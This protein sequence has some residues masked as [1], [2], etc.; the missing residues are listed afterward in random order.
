[1]SL[2]G[3]TFQ[4]LLWGHKTAKPKDI[5]IKSSAPVL[6]QFKVSSPSALLSVALQALRLKG[7]YKIRSCFSAQTCMAV[8]YIKLT[9]HITDAFTI[10]WNALYRFVSLRKQKLSK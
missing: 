3:Q 2:H 8:M 5:H 1:M 4:F 7:F 10:V 6:L 9:A